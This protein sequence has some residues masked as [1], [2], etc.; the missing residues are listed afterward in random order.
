MSYDIQDLVNEVKD[1]LYE[2]KNYNGE[3]ISDNLVIKIAKHFYNKGIE[4]AF[5]FS[6][7]NKHYEESFKL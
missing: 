6:E 3:P 4:E 1:L 2:N 5:N 7:I